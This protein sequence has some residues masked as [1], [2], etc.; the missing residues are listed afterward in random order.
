MNVDKHSK[1]Q[2]QRDVRRK[3]YVTSADRVLRDTSCRDDECCCHTVILCICT[4][5]V[6]YNITVYFIQLLHTV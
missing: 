6:L 3:H 5:I 4:I 1:F 2:K